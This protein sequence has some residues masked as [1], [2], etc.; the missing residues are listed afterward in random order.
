MVYSCNFYTLNVLKNDAKITQFRK[1]HTLNKQ[2]NYVLSYHLAA[3]TLQ[4]VDELLLQ[5]T[6]GQTLMQLNM[7][8]DYFL[9]SDTESL[10]TDDTHAFYVQ[11]KFM[12]HL[13]ASNLSQSDS[14]HEHIQKALHNVR[15]YLKKQ[16][17]ISF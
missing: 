3:A 15:D 9:L 7:E 8:R 16:S 14:Y 13:L 1:V 6:E 17:T 2:L 11:Q 12:T 4:W 5:N 10:I